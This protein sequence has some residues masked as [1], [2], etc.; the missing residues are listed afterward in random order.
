MEVYFK[1]L[2]TCTKLMFGNK[3]YQQKSHKTL[4]H[5]TAVQENETFEYIYY[6]Y[7]VY[8]DNFINSPKIMIN[9]CYNRKVVH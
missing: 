2:C 5:S 8:F 6:I 7:T 1:L 4:Y 9:C 3:M